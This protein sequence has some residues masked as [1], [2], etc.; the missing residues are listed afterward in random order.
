MA[1]PES[2][3]LRELTEE[4]PPQGLTPPETRP[5]D[6]EPEREKKRGQIAL[7]LILLLVGIVFGSFVTL[8]FGWVKPDALEKLL[9]VVFAPIVG[10]VGAVTGFYYGGKARP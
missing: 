8:S 1:P 2:V 10:L 5:Y 4:E 7:I 3:E 6:P 9:T